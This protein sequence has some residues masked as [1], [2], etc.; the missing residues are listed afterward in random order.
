MLQRL[1]VLPLI[2]LAAA[3]PSLNA[4]APRSFE[5]DSYQDFLKGKSSNVAIDTEGVL[6]L[7]NAA[8]EAGAMPESTVWCAATDAAGNLYVGTGFEGRVIKIAPD[9][10]STT[11]F[12]SEETHVTAIAMDGAGTIYAAT[13]PNGKIYAISPAGKDEVYV[14]TEDKYI[15][16]MVFDAA[17][18][19]YA[20][21]GDK[22]I[23]R[24]ISRAKEAT[25]FFSSGDG[26]IVSLAIDAA[27]N[28]LAGGD[29]RGAIYRISPS[30]KALAIWS[31]DLR[32]VRSILVR[33][34][35]SIIA[36]ASEGRRE[37]EPAIP[38][39][40]PAV[41]PAQVQV[42]GVTAE[43]TT[44]V[45][46][47]SAAGITFTPAGTVKPQAEKKLRGLL[48]Q[49]RAD[50]G[51][52]ELWR[53]DEDTIYAVAEAGAGRFMVAT[54][55]RGRL[56]WVSEDSRSGLAAELDG[57]Q[58]TA[59]V[60]FGRDRLLCGVNNR[61]AVYRLSDAMASQGTFTSHVQ[62]AGW[63]SNWGVV[64]W[65]GRGSAIGISTRTGNTPEPD[66][67]WSD[68]SV[69]M[70][71]P[72]GEQI[73]SPSGRYLQWKASFAPGAGGESAELDEVTINYQQQNAPP[74]I[75]SVTV[76]APGE[77]YQK[78]FSTG[79]GEYLG[80]DDLNGKGRADQ[81]SGAPMGALTQASPQGKKLYA[82][83]MQTILWTG[84]DPNGDE[85]VFTLSFKQIEE[86]SWRVLKTGTRQ[87]ALVVDTTALPDGVYRIKI[88]ASDEEDNA[89]AEAQ[90]AT[91]ESATFV[92]DNAPPRISPPVASGS[93]LA[94]VV[95]D[96]TSPISALA[97]S[98]NGGKWQ[99]LFPKDRICDGLEER[100]EAPKPQPGQLMVIKAVDARGNFAVMK[101]GS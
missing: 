7:S 44:T 69:P 92:V 72:T 15:W 63:I 20:G 65:A 90:T 96:T 48:V 24:K 17:G 94:F 89:K 79:E 42:A 35:G 31:S 1:I 4:A 95:T 28:L 68:W 88:D 21:T 82:Q 61:A 3:S 60:R 50:G 53:S 97:L 58:C 5:F 75:P 40:P 83:G 46:S 77:V 54:G 91:R 32:E 86:K 23:V 41:V 8:V 78:S 6:R 47:E 51:V 38:P 76:S 55:S 36:G 43:V 57:E 99:P 11:F 100:V 52:R 13:S 34:D 2:V 18:N 29:T 16:A 49:I 19:L 59:L 37:G 9:G 25:A 93:A 101:V 81:Q 56:Y 98:V 30:G 73:P 39:R 70:K 26:N 45:E 67:T 74:R 12:D 22:G 14:K 80:G 87:T 27:G 85:L 62:D 64:R 10:K 33:P 71:N 84:D 66:A